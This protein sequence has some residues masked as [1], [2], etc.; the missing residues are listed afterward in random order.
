MRP[1]F[2]LC[3]VLHE[4]RHDFGKATG[5]GVLTD[6]GQLVFRRIRRFEANIRRRHYLHTVGLSAE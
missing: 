2:E 3:P 4:D 1:D 6:E 5:R